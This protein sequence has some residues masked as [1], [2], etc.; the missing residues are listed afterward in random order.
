MICY[1]LREQLSDIDHVLDPRQ[2]VSFL[3]K[4]ISTELTPSPA[5]KFA[6][7]LD[8]FTK[9]ILSEAEAMNTTSFNVLE[10]QAGES[11]S[12]SI[13]DWATFTEHNFFSLQL[14]ERSPA[15]IRRRFRSFP[16]KLLI[17]CPRY[18]KDAEWVVQEVAQKF[19]VEDEIDLSWLKSDGDVFQPTMEL[20]EENETGPVCD[21]IRMLFEMGFSQ[22]LARKALDRAGWDVEG[23]AEWLLM[24]PEQVLSN[25]SAQRK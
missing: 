6:A 23:A 5:D 17:S 13:E 15:Q 3:L 25:F 10:I 16:S 7:E 20:G 9:C 1:K 2:L 21:E 12:K 8:T 11:I 24:N 14:R 4:Q 18:F 19:H 22:K